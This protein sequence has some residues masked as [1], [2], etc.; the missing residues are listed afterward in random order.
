MRVGVE[1]T[2]VAH[3]GA[4]LRA[5]VDARLVVLD[6][7]QVGG[8]ADGTQFAAGHGGD[9]RHRVRRRG[10]A[11]PVGGDGGRPPTPAAHIHLEIPPGHVTLARFSLG[12]GV[13]ESDVGS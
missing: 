8:F 5:G 7:R 4:T 3:H 11:A 12:G 13:L 9:L 1:A 2:L 10:H 6:A